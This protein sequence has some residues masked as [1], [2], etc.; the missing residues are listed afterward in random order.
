MAEICLNSNDKKDL[1]NMILNIL[2]NI[3]LNDVI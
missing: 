2:N 3:I 1:N